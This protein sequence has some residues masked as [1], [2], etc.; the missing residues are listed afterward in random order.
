MRSKLDNQDE[1]IGALANALQ[2][3]L[4]EA[5]AAPPEQE[6]ELEFAQPPAHPEPVTAT[7]GDIESVASVCQSLTDVLMVCR[8]LKAVP[9]M[10]DEDRLYILQVACRM[11]GEPITNG[12]KI[13][14]GIKY[15]AE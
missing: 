3:H 6:Q 4:E 10:T 5:A 8:A 2:Q 11:A 13:R 1:A 14:A 9:N 12:I 15:V 7:K